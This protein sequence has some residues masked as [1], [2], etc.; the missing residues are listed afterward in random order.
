M[1]FIPLEGHGSLFARVLGVSNP[2]E[3]FIQH[4]GGLGMDGHSH[5]SQ[6]M[7]PKIT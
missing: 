6:T 4:S 5:L 2:M 7:G 3:M 1:C